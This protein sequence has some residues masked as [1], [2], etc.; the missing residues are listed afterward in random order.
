MIQE[1][2]TYEPDNLFSASHQVC[3][4]VGGKVTIASGTGKLSR[5]AI[6][7]MS[8]AVEGSTSDGAIG[9]YTGSNTP[10]AV[11][12][13]DIDAT[14]VAVDASVYFSGEFNGLKLIADEDVDITDHFVTLAKANIYVRNL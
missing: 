1:V 2:T 11:L 9:I 8:A 7:G 14:S 5:G 12:A 6:L 10:I 3:P 4:A 13:E